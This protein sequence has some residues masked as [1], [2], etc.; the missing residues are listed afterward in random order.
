[1][2]LEHCAIRGP[3]SMDDSS[4][5][6]WKGFYVAPH[7]IVALKH[8]AVSHFDVGLRV[9]AGGH[10]IIA[11]SEVEACNIGILV[12]YSKQLSFPSNYYVWYFKRLNKMQR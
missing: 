12:N 11:S 4:E 7:S 9:R 1:M 2:L 10:I 5:S 8:C 3:P 6:A